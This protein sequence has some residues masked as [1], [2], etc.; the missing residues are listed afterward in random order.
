[1]LVIVC[2]RLLLEENASTARYYVSYELWITIDI[3]MC[4]YDYDN[5]IHQGNSVFHEL[6]VCHQCIQDE[7]HSIIM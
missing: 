5:V 2:N 4:E 3:R 7:F 1:M 6:C